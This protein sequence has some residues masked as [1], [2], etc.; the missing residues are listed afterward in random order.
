MQSIHHHWCICHRFITINTYAIDLS[1]STH[2]E[3]L[4]THMKSIHGQQHVIIDSSS[5]TI[6]SRSSN[7]SSIDSSSSIIMWSIHR[8]QYR[9]NRV[10]IIRAQAIEYS[11]LCIC[12]RFIIIKTYAIDSS[13]STIPIYNR[14]SIIIMITSAIVSASWTRHGRY[15]KLLTQATPNKILSCVLHTTKLQWHGKPSCSR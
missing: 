3:R 10:I 14:V 2:R 9:C 11:P 4:S 8:N 7:V 5:S 13:S 12:H 1:P 15:Q 6:D